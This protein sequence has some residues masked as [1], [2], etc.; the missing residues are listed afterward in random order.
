[1]EFMFFFSNAHMVRK[2]W[3]DTRLPGRHERLLRRHGR[4]LRRDERL[5][6]RHGR[7]LRRHERLRHALTTLA[8]TQK[9]KR[10]YSQERGGLLRWKRRWQN[11][12]KDILSLRP[13]HGGHHTGGLH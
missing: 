1:M 13:E 4:S 8:H 5:L 3:N 9:A 2:G 7:S 6:R 11:I 12:P 10:R